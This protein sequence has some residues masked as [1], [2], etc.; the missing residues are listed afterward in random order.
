MKKIKILIAICICI[1]SGLACF[2][3]NLIYKWQVS[4]AETYQMSL[5]EW[6][7]SAEGTGMIMEGVGAVGISLIGSSIFLVCVDWVINRVEE[8]R[9]REAEIERKRLEISGQMRTDPKNSLQRLRNIGNFERELF[10]N[11]FFVG[12]DFSDLILDNIDFSESNLSNTKFDNASLIGANLSNCIMLESSI[13][14]A[15]LAF[16]NLTGTNLS[17][18]EFKSAYSLRNAI[19]PDGKKYDGR[20]MLE[21]DVQEAKKLGYDIINDELQRKTFYQNANKGK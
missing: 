10:T 14:N 4:S 20:F 8:Q 19:L 1:F 7:Q 11:Q 13:E 2:G 12:C 3:A 6:L 21:G 16:A 15:K 5:N 18:T 17:D 9:K